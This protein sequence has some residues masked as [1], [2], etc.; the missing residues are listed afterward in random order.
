MIKVTPAVLCGGSGTRLWPFSRTGLQKQFMCL[1]GN[2]SLFQQAVLCLKNLGS[3]VV[4]VESPIIVTG[5]DYRF[6]AS[7]ATP[8]LSVDYVAME[9]CPGNGLYG[10]NG[11][12]VSW[13]ERSRCLGSCLGPIAQGRQRKCPRR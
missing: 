5:E 2:E 12:I 3:E 11:S 8:S 9:K 10:Q 13:L 6:L 1:T 4:E 7:E